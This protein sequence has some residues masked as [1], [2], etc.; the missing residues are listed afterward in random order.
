M[1]IMLL[2]GAALPVL[3]QEPALPTAADLE[4]RRLD[5]NIRKARLEAELAQLEAERL[6]LEAAPSPASG[7]A[8]TTHDPFAGRL[9]M[10]RKPVRL[11]RKGVAVGELPALTV[12][13]AAPAAEPGWIIVQYEGES[14]EAPA[15][16]FALEEDLLGEARRTESA[17]L[18]DLEL[19]EAEVQ[20]L[21]DQQ[22]RL[23]GLVQALESELRHVVVSSRSSSIRVSDEEGRATLV[24]ES[25]ARSTLGEWRRDLRR[26]SRQIELAEQDLFL[27]RSHWER[28]RQ[29]RERLEAA[30]TVFRDERT[31]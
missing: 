3:A 4:Q 21:Q 17:A 1:W 14:Y 24:S 10:A 15:E 23:D 2:V 13:P 30:F 22:S 31:P 5:L 11:L 27:L 16:P 12:V 6:R 25:S 7:E 19:R 20:Q 8:A 26:V 9:R 18:R 29:V 28:S